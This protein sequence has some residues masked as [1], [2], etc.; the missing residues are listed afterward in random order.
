MG[1][2]LV[3]LAL[4][5]FVQTAFTAPANVGARSSI[6]GSAVSPSSCSGVY[7][8]LATYGPAQ[9]YCSSKYATPAPTDLMK[10][11]KREL[12]DLWG[13]LSGDHS[14]GKC[15]KAQCQCPSSMS[16]EETAEYWASVLQ[17]SDSK[18]SS[19]CSDIGVTGTAAAVSVTLPP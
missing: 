13:S 4:A 15:T 10:L 12:W 3:P 7:S 6:A 14:S 9:S 17:M 5:I 18:I 19:F 8:A 11:S 16:T 2:S 1:H